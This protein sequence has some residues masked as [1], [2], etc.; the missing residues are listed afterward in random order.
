LVKWRLYTGD[1]DQS[2]IQI[3]DVETG[4]LRALTGAT[5]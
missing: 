2:T 3:L 4:A 1:A 5:A